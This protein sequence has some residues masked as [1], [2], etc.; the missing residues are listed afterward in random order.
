MPGDLGLK[1]ALKKTPKPTFYFSGIMQFPSQ[2]EL[3]TAPED[4]G[5]NPSNFPL[6]R[7]TDSVKSR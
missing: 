5:Q 3:F 2:N 7:G 1:M 4:P 6:K